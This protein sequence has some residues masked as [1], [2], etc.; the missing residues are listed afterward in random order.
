M[1][2]NNIFPITFD[3]NETEE[4]VENYIFSEFTTFD[5]NETEENTNFSEFS[6]DVNNS[7]EVVDR[8]YSEYLEIQENDKFYRVNMFNL[9]IL[10]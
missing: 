8:V 7:N 6:F 5:M 2:H 4:A 3:M 1:I 10:E 9:N